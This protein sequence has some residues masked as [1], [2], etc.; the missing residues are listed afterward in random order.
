MKLVV[1]GGQLED[2]RRRAG[3]ELEGWDL[4]VE[5][6]EWKRNDFAQTGQTRRLWPYIRLTSFRTTKKLVQSHNLTLVAITLPTSGFL[7]QKA[8]EMCHVKV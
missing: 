4:H 8:N 6:D 3:E 2:S 5:M 1:A 7:N